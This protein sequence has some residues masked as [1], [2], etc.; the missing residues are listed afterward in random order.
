MLSLLNRKVVLW[1]SEEGISVKREKGKRK[2]HGLNMLCATY[3]S[4]ITHDNLLRGG[5]ITIS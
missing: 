5:M 1:R 3:H 4:G 2:Q